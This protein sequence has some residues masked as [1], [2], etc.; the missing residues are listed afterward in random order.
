MDNPRALLLVGVSTRALAASVRRSGYRGFFLALDFFADVDHPPGCRCLALGQ[1]ASGPVT[2]AALM[3]AAA[4]LMRTGGARRPDAV[5]F[6]GGMENHPRLLSRLEERTRVLG[7]T[8]RSVS[9]LGNIANFL[10]FLDRRSVPHPRTWILPKPARSLPLEAIRLAHEGR[11]LWKPVHGGGGVRI[12]SVVPRRCGHTNAGAIVSLGDLPR[13][14]YLQEEL[15]GIAGSVSFIADGRR[16]RILG[17]CQAVRDAAVLGPSGHA[18]GGS[19]FGPPG[20]WLSARARKA[21]ERAAEAATWEFELR[22]LNGIDFVLERGVPRILEINPRYTASMELIEEASGGALF[23]LH[24]EACE[25][26]RLPGHLRWAIGRRRFPEEAKPQRAVARGSDTRGAR[27]RR[28]RWRGKAILYAPERMIAG[29]PDPLLEVGARDVPGAGAVL[30]KG[31]PVCTVAATA[32]S[33]A[34]CRQA[35]RLRARHLCGLFGIW[36]R[37]RPAS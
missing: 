35:L 31:W 18:Y 22:G 25:R 4:A 15:R 16:C 24:R 14:G 30:R 2:T 9:A 33:A 23:A 32:D 11:L 37:M 3:R 5:A 1:E 36:R 26:R 13:G 29:P 7:N 17:F 28:G 20:E 12:R 34:K 6:S 19:L 27:A 10:R 8:A 21:L